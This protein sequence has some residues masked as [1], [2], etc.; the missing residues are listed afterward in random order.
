LCCELPKNAF[1]S[2]LIKVTH[3]KNGFENIT[4]VF[5]ILL[6]SFFS[7]KGFDKISRCLVRSLKVPAKAIPLFSEICIPTKKPFQCWWN[8]CTGKWSHFS[9]GGINIPTKSHFNVGRIYRAAKSH[10]SV[11]EIYVSAKMPRP[12]FNGGGI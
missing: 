7:R 8:L 10:F 3:R 6:I 9:V 12:H 11:G 1:V 2:V 4:L 5:N